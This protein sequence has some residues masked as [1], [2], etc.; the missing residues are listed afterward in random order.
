MTTH[1]NI[2][3]LSLTTKEFQ[4]LGSFIQQSVGIKMPAEKKVMLEGRLRRRLRSLSMDSFSQY[5]DYLFSAEGFEEEII[6]MIDVVTTNKTEFFRESAQI[7]RAH[8]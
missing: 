4:Q 5:I 2:Y 7:G 8:V 6:H 1:S 3:E